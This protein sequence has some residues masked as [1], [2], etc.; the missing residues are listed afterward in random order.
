VKAQGFNLRTNVAP[1]LSLKALPTFVPSTPSSSLKSKVVSENTFEELVKSIR[2]LKVEM[3][4][5]KKDHTPSN[6]RP[7]DG[8]KEFTM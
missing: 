4:A 1:L 7:S 5:L 6:S 2:E 3:N 8:S